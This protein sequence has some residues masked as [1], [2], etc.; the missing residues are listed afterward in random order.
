MFGRGL[1]QVFKFVS[2]GGLYECREMDGRRTGGG[3]DQPHT[4]QSHTKT[5]HQPIVITWIQSFP[6]A[7]ES[8]AKERKRDDETVV[9]KRALPLRFKL[10]LRV[11]SVHSFGLFFNLPISLVKNSDG[12]PPPPPPPR[13]RCEKSRRGGER[14][15]EG[16]RGLDE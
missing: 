3:I 14:R 4:T 10:K 8:T 1:L 5:P 7:H 15:E 6:I 13:R 16:K 2:I 9:S 11:V 12:P